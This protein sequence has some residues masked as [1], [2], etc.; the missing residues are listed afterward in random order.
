M[1][2]WGD[3]EHAVKKGIEYGTPEGLAY[4]AFERAFK[5]K[6]KRKPT[7]DEVAHFKSIKAAHGAVGD[8]PNLPPSMPALQP[9][10]THSWLESLESDLQAVKDKVVGETVAALVVAFLLIRAASKR[11]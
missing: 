11:R 2:F 10:A 3:I 7:A 4:A 1:S 9:A 8:V 5:R 6:H